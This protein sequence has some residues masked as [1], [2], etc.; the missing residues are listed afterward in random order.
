MLFNKSCFEVTFF[1]CEFY[2]CSFF[3]A[4]FSCHFYGYSDAVLASSIVMDFHCFFHNSFNR[5]FYYL[6][7]SMV[8]YNRTFSHMYKYDLPISIENRTFFSAVEA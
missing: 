1:V 2:E 7:F 4:Y 8:Q 5:T 6:S 3:E